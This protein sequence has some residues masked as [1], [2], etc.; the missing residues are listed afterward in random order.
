MSL[1]RFALLFVVF[2]DVMGQGLVFP[3]VTTIVM[4]PTQG[5][6]PAHTATSL[7]EIDYGVVIG[8]FFL[9]WFLGAAYISKLSDYIG[10]KK[11][12]LICL[13]GA[14]AGYVLTIIALYLSN[15]ALLLLGRAVSGF[16]AGNQPIA[17]AALIDISRDD[18]EKAGNLGMIVA[19]SALGL[20]GGPL[21]AGVLSDADLLGAYASLELPFYGALLLVLLN[22]ACIIWGF[23]E[24]KVPRRKIDF[25]LSEVFLTLWR[26]YQRP[27]VLRLSIVLF[28]IFLGLNSYY[29]FLDDYL[30]SRFNFG[31]LQNSL[32]MM[33]LG[34]T[35]ALGSGMLVAPLNKRFPKIRIVTVC[36][37]FLAVMDVLYMLNPVALLAYVLLAPLMIVYGVT[38][39][40]MLGLFSAAVDAS[41]QGWVMGVTIALY[42]LGSGSVSLIGGSLMS[43]DIYTPFFIS[44][45]AYVIAFGLINTIWRVQRVR[46]LDER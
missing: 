13:A 37:V 40:T 35:M 33:V 19:A 12:I 2:I 7:R 11:G 24:P 26:V 27:T 45:S 32:I 21:M 30:F 4:D 14:F 3:I 5:F 18:D 38:Y 6:L 15:F 16:T 17:Q 36:V 31:T 22:T 9:A 20:V 1:S 43:L 10:R 25:G 46:A 42:T 41:E 29:V 23:Q 44:I 28:F 39:P 34:G 8:V